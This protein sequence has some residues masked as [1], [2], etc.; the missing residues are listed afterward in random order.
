MRRRRSLVRAGLWLLVL[1]P[2]I[3]ATA[4]APPAGAPGATRTAAM[5]PVGATAA[6]G[7]Q[8]PAGGRAAGG[9]A[10]AGTA[11]AG[12]AAAGTAA[13]GTAAPVGGTAVPYEP[14][15]PDQPMMFPRDFGSHPG[16]RTEWWYVTGWLTTAR[17]ESLGFQVTFFRTRPGIDEDNP[18]AFSA[19]QLIIGHVALSDTHRGRL[20]QDQRVERAVFGTADASTADTRVWVDGWRLERTADGYVAHLAADGFTLQLTLRPTQ[21]PLIEGEAGFSRKGPEPQAASHYYSVPHLAVAGVITRAGAEDRVTGEAWL[22]HEWSSEYLDA[23]AVGWDWTGIN[24]ADGSSLMAFRIRGRD[25]STRWSGA[26]LRRATGTA[27]YS[28]TEVRFEPAEWW[29]SPRTGIDYP[30]GMRVQVGEVALEL[31]P[32]MPDQENDTRLSTGAIYWEGAVRA[33]EQGREAGRGY[34]ELTGYGERL[35]LR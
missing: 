35:R 29:P 22:D 23:Q 7:A 12:T 32:L 19:R 1:L 34:L 26:T 5:T 14:V 4:P 20:W 2:G 27:T 3:A 33:L 10:A 28:G 18:S 9:T 11:A 24:L 17:H 25:G 30:V 13:G 31:V 16:F 15:L 21:P 8:T 6:G